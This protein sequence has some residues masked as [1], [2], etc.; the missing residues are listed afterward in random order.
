[1]ALMILIPSL[2][3]LY[4]FKDQVGDKLV[5][6]IFLLVIPILGFIILWRVLH[7]FISILKGLERVAAGEAVNLDVSEGPNQVREMAEIVGALN[8]LTEDFRENSR[9][10]ETLIHQFATLT[11]LTEVSA[12]I[13]DINELL[14][15][16]LKK[17]MGATHARTGTI[18]LVREDGAG[19]DI[20]AAEGWSPAMMGP[21]SPD[22]T[23][24]GTV[25]ETGEPFLVENLEEVPGLERPSDPDRYSSP[26]FLIMPLKAKTTTVGALC[27][28][29]RALASPFSQHDQQFLTV[30][31]GQIGFAVENA[32]LLH[33]AREAASKLTETVQVQELKLQDAYQQIIQSE[34][35]SA[36]GQLIAGV[37]HEINNPLTTIVGYTDL[38]LENPSA[39]QNDRKL[40]TILSEA[41]RA[42]R[43][44]QNLLSFAR[45]KKPERRAA[46]LNELVQNIADLRQ[47]DL[48]A[49]N[50]NLTIDL[51]DRIPLTLVDADQI[52]QVLLNMV[53]NSAQAIPAGAP[54][55]IVV[56]TRREGDWL[57]VWVEDNGK[58]IPE[59]LKEK[60][61]DPFFSTKG[62]NTNSG[63]GLSISYGIV[64][65]HGGDIL[66]DSREG[67]G[68]TL[69]IRL[70]VIHPLTEGAG[71]RTEEAPSSFPPAED[72]RALV[73][74]DEPTIASLLQ[75]ILDTVGFQ[76]DVAHSGKEALHRLEDRDYEVVI[77]DL[78]MPEIDGR[79][80]YREIRQSRVRLKDRFILT[81]GDVADPQARQFAER[82]GI[83]L[84][85]KPFTRQHILEAVFQCVQ[86]RTT[87]TSLSL[88]S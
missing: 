75:E 68:A 81:S 39:D 18:M 55:R 47:Y 23:L 28:S 25:I 65:E 61:F 78:R 71:R 87:Q 57:R 43:I 40:K 54:G 44:V 64:K 85:P 73:I 7:S 67:S 60:I 20:A 53:N 49:R 69:T 11:E 17:A 31:L 62:E 10:L 79:E 50:I 33:Q 3:V 15:L 83:Q 38:V 76:T 27:L 34:K 77:C 6:L 35:L 14:S 22:D 72:R 4:L 12:K 70:P 21:I 45:E 29:E 26:S 36:L 42:T 41:K 5:T 1:M 84:V 80:I 51:D 16:V 63:L 82:N 2:G 19:L 30:L 46:N 88:A 8:R 86:N 32:R 48:R 56:G 52:Q 58:G 37:A 74:D 59:S 13:P 24:A 66:V 9:Q